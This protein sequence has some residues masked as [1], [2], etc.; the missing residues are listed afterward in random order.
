MAKM[1]FILSAKYPRHTPALFPLSLYYV[2]H[3]ETGTEI[4]RGYGKGIYIYKDICEM[5]DPPQQRLAAI[6]VS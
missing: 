2:P 3:Q 5:E 6:E 1:Q 4:Y